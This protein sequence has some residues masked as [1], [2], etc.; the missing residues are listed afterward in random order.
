MVKDHTGL[1][2]TGGLLTSGKR[3]RQIKSL[4]VGSG[5][6]TDVSADRELRFRWAALLLDLSIDISRYAEEF[7]RILSLPGWHFTERPQHFQGIGSFTITPSSL[8]AASDNRDCTLTSVTAA[9]LTRTSLPGFLLWFSHPP[10]NPADTP[11]A[12]ANWRWDMPASL[13]AIAIL[14]PMSMA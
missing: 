2:V 7:D 11:T 13:R 1:L 3:T 10:T 12:L 5:P 8:P 14:W 9:I 6:L 4:P